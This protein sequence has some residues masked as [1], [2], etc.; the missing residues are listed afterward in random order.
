MF[1]GFRSRKFCVNCV[2]DELVEQIYDALIDDDLDL[3]TE[4]TENFESHDLY[5]SHSKYK[6]SS[7]LNKRPAI[8]HAAAFFGA[9]SIFQYLKDG[10]EVDMTK[11][12]F[13]ER[14]VQHFAAAGGNLSIMR[15]FDTIS[16]KTDQKNRTS[17]FYAVKYGHMDIV[18]YL[19][20]KGLTFDG[21]V[22]K[23]LY[24][25]CFLGE[26]EIVQF[27]ASQIDSVSFILSTDRSSCM[28]A[29]ASSG[30]A[31]LIRFL[32][33][34]LPSINIMSETLVSALNIA[35]ESGS[36]E[37]VKALVELNVVINLPQKKQVPIVQA[38]KNGHLDIVKYLYDHGADVNLRTSQDDSALQVA[39]KNNHPRVVKFLLKHGAMVKPNE[40]KQLLITA[41]QSGGASLLDI[42][43]KMSKIPLNTLGVEALTNAI[44]SHNAGAVRYFLEH[45]VPI[46]SLRADSIQPLMHDF[47]DIETMKVL[48]E[49]NFI[50]AFDSQKSPL[51][52]Y[53]VKYNCP[54]IFELLISN[55]AIINQQI[56][57]EHDL[58][59]LAA[60]KCSAQLMKLLVAQAS[61]ITMHI[62]K[63]PLTELLKRWESNTEN[64]TNDFIEIA[65]IL[66]EH[67]VKCNQTKQEAL[68]AGN[69]A[70]EIGNIEALK[71]AY[72]GGADF[73]ATKVVKGKEK[74][75]AYF[76]KNITKDHIKFLDFLLMKGLIDPNTVD[77][78]GENM[79]HH[80]MRS[81]KV[82]IEAIN[83]LLE[84]GV[85]INAQSKKGLTPLMV[86]CEKGHFSIFPYLIDH[87]ANPN[88]VDEDGQTV[89]HYLAKIPLGL[90]PFKILLDCGM[91]INLAT[92]N[93]ETPF[94]LLMKRKPKD[95]EFRVSNENTAQVALYMIERGANIFIFP[96]GYK[97]LLEKCEKLKNQALIQKV[98]E[99][100]SQ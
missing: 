38:A 33:S 59:A 68:D 14:G 62:S 75:P 100:F 92:K 21:D 39:T 86:A 6:I 87:G 61:D 52:V 24:E 55:G 44:N 56:I 22:S 67:G 89:L 40:C 1:W 11:L 8:I 18:K 71:A 54:K 80:L 77:S 64:K 49:L 2:P 42:V 47:E 46:T 26:L 32:A 60:S 28:T 94:I 48:V 79:F 43:M 70:L 10:I 69:S 65:R 4:I 30:N 78:G 34:K 36:L 25:A 83:F 12:D 23:I 17:M 29:A 15:S 96:G 63:S 20:S 82:H 72:E 76:R 73:S 97:T 9:E 95:E 51:I 35:A 45:G 27:V 58:I 41:A 99:K 31:D 85:D 84:A 16:K 19:W 81:Y 93:N 53:C 90:Y 13:L 5:L 37:A 98:K 7:I 3:Y 66:T 74:V 91:N 57:E 50:K 88:I